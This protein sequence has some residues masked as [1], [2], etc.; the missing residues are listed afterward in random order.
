LIALRF[1]SATEFIEVAQALEACIAESH[2]G[3]AI[4]GKRKDIDVSLG[5]PPL[6]K[7]GKP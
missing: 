3:Q 6:L 2:Q 7:R 5:R 1:E 4:L